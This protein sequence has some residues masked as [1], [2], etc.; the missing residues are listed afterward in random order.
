[1]VFPC[2]SNQTGFPMKLAI[3]VLTK[4]KYCMPPT[5]IVPQTFFWT[6]AIQDFFTL[7]TN[8]K[9]EDVNKIIDALTDDYNYTFDNTWFYSALLKR[10]SAKPGNVFRGFGISYTNNTF[11]PEPNRDSDIEDLSLNING[12][13]AMDIQELIEKE[14]RVGRIAAYNTVRILRGQSPNFIQDDVHNN[15]YFAVKR[16]KSIQ[17]HLRLVD[18][19]RNEYAKIVQNI[20]DASIGVRN[21]GDRKLVKGNAFD[22]VFKNEID[23]VE[24]FI[25]RVFNSTKPFKLWGLKSEIEKDYYK[26]MAVDLHAGGILHFDIAKDMIRVG[27]YD[28]TCGNTILR[29]FTNLQ[30]HFDSKIIC[31]QLCD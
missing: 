26:V 9:S 16:G 11:S 25:N 4:S 14:P 2:N 17:D 31:S 10:F 28:G 19:C 22:F 18:T 8:E 30:I 24:L 13:M 3:Q 21:S 6:Q 29:L 12:S 1:M 20:E 15:G 23:D 5:Q 27:I 7:H